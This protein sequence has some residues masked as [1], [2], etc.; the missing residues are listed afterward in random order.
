MKIISI[1]LSLL[2]ITQSFIFAYSDK[3][4]PIIEK[5]IKQNSIDQKDLNGIAELDKLQ[6][7]RNSI[8]AYYGYIFKNQDLNIYF[9]QYKWYKPAYS[10]VENKLTDVDK[11]NV[12]IIQYYELKIK[13]ELL[14]KQNK[15][16]YSITLSDKD[17]L[18]IG[19]WQAAPHLAS[20]WV[21][22]YAFYN[23][24]KVIFRSNQ[25]NGENRLL[26]KIG[27]WKIEKNKIIIEY[28]AK[29]ILVGGTLMPAFGSI[30]TEKYIAGAT[31]MQ[32]E[33]KPSEVVSFEI[34]EIMK[35][36]IKDRSNYYIVTIDK[37]T[38]WKLRED[39]NDYN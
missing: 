12:E 31:P 7:L 18:L 27:Y 35:D 24:R 26:S 8:Y 37:N 38:Y 1:T 3:L 16:E 23:N 30:A 13:R 29:E 22:S 5:I 34:S 9:K 10:N 17:K 20:G 11:N 19:I 36:M 21:E 28:I 4:T 32:I 2:F 33:I 6:I 25:M 15:A 39:P 14:L